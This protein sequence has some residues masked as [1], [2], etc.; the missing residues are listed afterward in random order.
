MAINQTEKGQ[1]SKLSEEVIYQIK[2][3]TKRMQLRLDH[4]IDRRINDKEKFYK[5]SLY[6]HIPH[7]S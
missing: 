5:I 1:T 7:P 3:R 2:K 4:K 6:S